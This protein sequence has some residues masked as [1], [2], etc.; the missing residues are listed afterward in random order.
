MDR[1]KRKKVIEEHITPT[2]S[3]RELNAADRRVLKKIINLKCDICD[4]IEKNQVLDIKRLY[5]LIDEINTTISIWTKK[6]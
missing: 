6:D 2:N 4:E 3:W 1:E 5:R